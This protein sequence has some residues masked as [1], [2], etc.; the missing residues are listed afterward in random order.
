M[1]WLRKNLLWTHTKEDMK[2][3]K[4]TFEQMLAYDKHGLKEC[5]HCNGYG[6]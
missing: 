6:G 3:P 4:Y 2:L 1:L 5:P